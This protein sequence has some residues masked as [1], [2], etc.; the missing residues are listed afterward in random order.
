MSVD[1][2]REELLEKVFRLLSCGHSYVVES[3]PVEIHRPY[4]SSHPFG[5]LEHDT[6]FVVAKVS[7]G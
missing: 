5:T 6:Y 1:P 2:S 7:N 4:V 3:D